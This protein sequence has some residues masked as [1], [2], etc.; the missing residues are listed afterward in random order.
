MMRFH[1][2]AVPW[3]PIGL[4]SA[5]ANISTIS[6]RASSLMSR[7]IGHAGETLG[8]HAIEDI[9]GEAAQMLPCCMGI[10]L[11]GGRPGKELISEP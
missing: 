1:W 9:C 6:P 2:R 7:S 11:F 5:R 10:A 8:P 4:V 3:P